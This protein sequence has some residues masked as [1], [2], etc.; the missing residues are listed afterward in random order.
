MGL[1]CLVSVYLSVYINLFLITLEFWFWGAIEL[2][3]GRNIIYI[4]S[5]LHTSLGVFSFHQLKMSA[6]KILYLLIQCTT[7][8]IISSTVW[9]VKHKNPIFMYKQL[10]KPF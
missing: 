9:H 2:K 5:K 8:F 4:K 6:I 10:Q 1:K 7:A 3:F